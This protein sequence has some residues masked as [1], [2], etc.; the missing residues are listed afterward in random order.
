M[1]TNITEQIEKLQSEL[2][3]LKELNNQGEAKEGEWWW[4]IDSNSEYSAL[5]L[6]GKGFGWT[7]SGKFS[8]CFIEIVRFGQTVRKATDEEVCQAFKKHLEA[9]G[10]TKGCKF[11]S[12][13]TSNEYIYDGKIYLDTNQ[14]PVSNF[15]TILGSVTLNLAELVKDEKIMVGEHLVE[16]R[17]NRMI[18]V[19]D[20]FFTD[21]NIKT[22]LPANPDLF[23]KILK[24]M[25]SGS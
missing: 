17:E 5:R 8:D 25:E 16:F 20:S 11:K 15:G 4:L 2:D 13:V 18:L 21:H 24:R 10:W 22:L 7:F 3:R 1:K 19:N 9:N 23:G 6:W 14:M 12:A